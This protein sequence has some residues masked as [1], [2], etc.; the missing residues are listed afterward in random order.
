M[1]SL[2]GMIDYRGLLK[3]QRKTKIISM[4]AKECEVRGT[5]ATG[6]A[7]IS[8]EHLEIYKRPLPA[9][10]MRFHLPHDCHIIMGHTRLATQGSE[11]F[12][13]N[14]HPFS[15]Q[16]SNTHF[17]LA[18]NGVIHNDLCLRKKEVLPPTA[19]QTDSYIAVQLIEKQHTLNFDSLR[20]MAEKIEGTFSFTLLDE[21]GN[22]Y[23]IKGDSP[24]CIYHYPKQGFY[25]YASTEELL[26]KVVKKLHFN[27][28]R[29][30]T[31]GSTCGDI[32]QIDLNGNLIRSKFNTARLETWRTP[33]QF[34]TQSHYLFST[35]LPYRSKYQQDLVNFAKYCG[36][37]EDDVDL[38]LDCGYDEWEI[39]ELLYDPPAFQACISNN[40]HD[41]PYPSR[42][43][44]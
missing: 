22:F 8:K 32:I 30:E 23:F 26:Q 41:A 18:H 15:G 33:Y 12:N 27:G 20:Y 24:L 36:V 42:Y 31:I 40:I 19:I 43:Y 11:Q 6:I 39:E 25:L 5:D 37:S 9:H 38:L 10:K 3:N 44:L 17:V 4:L 2:F 13:Q 14:N 28:L 7:Y 21:Q 35:Q 1:C 16:T 29:P 34:N